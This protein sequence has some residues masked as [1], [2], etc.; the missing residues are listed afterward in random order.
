MLVE[1]TPLSICPA[2]RV[3]P[4]HNASLVEFTTSLRPLNAT[5]GH[6]NTR[7]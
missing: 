1:F 6:L 7:I 2:S 3:H 5:I 4:F